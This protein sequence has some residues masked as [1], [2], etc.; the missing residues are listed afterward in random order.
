MLRFAISLIVAGNWDFSFWQKP[1]I[2]QKKAD[3]GHEICGPA[4]TGLVPTPDENPHSRS[5][6]A[7]EWGTL[8][9]IF[10]L[11]GGLPGPAARPEPRY[12]IGEIN[13]VFSSLTLE[14]NL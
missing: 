13:F 12:S 11:N 6:R 10:E 3:M 5:L 2:C 4:A 14:C 9:K 1:H 7:L 8:V